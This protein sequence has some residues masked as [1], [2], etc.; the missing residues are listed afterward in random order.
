MGRNSMSGCTTASTPSMSLADHA[1][2]KR[3]TSSAWSVLA[4]SMAAATGYGRRVSDRW[5]TFDC[6]GTLVDW[7]AGIGAQLARALGGEAGP[8]LERYH[9]VEPRIQRER[10]DA[11]YRDVMA[12][13]LAE[14]AAER[15]VELPGHERDAL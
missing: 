14:L 10:P 15:G 12:S 5:A 2:E 8:L 4:H 13:A 7:N 3:R 9:A 6:Y 11:S 1:A